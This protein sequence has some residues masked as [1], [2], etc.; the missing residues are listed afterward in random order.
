MKFDTSMN[1]PLPKYIEGIPLL[2]ATKNRGRGLELDN[3][4]QEI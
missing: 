1:G 2:A 3:Q 4:T